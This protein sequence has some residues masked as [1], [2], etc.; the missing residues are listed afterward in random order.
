MR[1]LVPGG[2]LFIGDV[3]ELRTVRC[4]HTAIQLG[5]GSADLDTIER[6]VRMEKELLLD[7][8]FF[9]ALTVA[10]AW[11]SSPNEAPTTTN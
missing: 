4:L 7:P 6:A 2:M 11:T 10:P 8:A 5:R 1:L 3:R 9:T